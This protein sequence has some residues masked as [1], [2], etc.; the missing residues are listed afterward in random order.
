[1]AD[2]SRM[3]PARAAAGAAPAQSLAVARS[4]SASALPN[5]EEPIT[6]LQMMRDSPSHHKIFLLMV[7]L[8]VLC[9]V[10]ERIVLFSLFLT[11]DATASLNEKAYEAALRGSLYFLLI[12][13]LSACFVG[14]FGIHAIL[15]TNAFEMAAFFFASLMLIIRL[16]LEFL[17]KSDN[18]CTGGNEVLCA[19]FLTVAVFFVAVAM[20]FTLAIYRDL[21]WKRY[22]AI[23]AEVTTRRMYRLF[24]LFSAVRKLDLQF[25]MVTLVTGLVFFWDALDKDSRDEIAIGINISLFAVELAWERLGVLGVRSENA[26]MLYF[27]WAFSFGLPGFILYVLLNK[28]HLFNLILDPKFGDRFVEVQ[29]TIAVMAVLA[30]LNRVATV[31]CSVLLYVNFGPNYVGLRRI[32]MSDRRSKFNRKRQTQFAGSKG[33]GSK[34]GGAV[35]AGES[36]PSVDGPSSAAADVQLRDLSAPAAGTAVSTT[37]PFAATTA[38]ASGGAAGTGTGTA[39]VQE[40]A[41]AASVVLTVSSSGG[42]GGGADAGSSSGGSSGP[43]RPPTRAER[44]GSAAAGGSI[45]SGGRIN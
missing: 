9:N 37:N 19:S 15:Q 2:A 5:V 6:Y 31:V 13:L 12:I 40:W 29:V 32:I 10:V 4:A 3:P 36:T 38:S 20:G 39:P 43:G 28:D 23:G 42:E 14:Y 41:S 7:V 25:S 24:E 34:A 27:F 35:G 16:A 22:K 1:M 45:G 21:E 17:S 18:E 11:N 8:Q 30:V 26:L 33:P 44:V